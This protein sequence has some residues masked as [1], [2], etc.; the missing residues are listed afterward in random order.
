MSAIWG[1]IDFKGNTISKVHKEILR[2]AYQDCKIDR[3]EEYA[4]RHIYMGCGIQ[5]FTKE[6]E[7]EILP[8]KQ[9]K[10]IITADVMI[11]NRMQLAE[12]LNIEITENIADGKLLCDY[13]MKYPKQSLNDMLGAYAFVDYDEEKEQATIVC[14]AV[15]NRFVHYMLL[16]R[17][18]YFSSLLQ[19]LEQIMENVH[20]N[21]P[22]NHRWISDYI[23]QDNYNMF[24][25]CEETPIEGILRTAPGQSVKISKTGRIKKEKYWDPFRDQKRIRFANDE[26]YKK[27]FLNLY[28]E[29]VNCL[30]RANGE[31]AIFLSG[32][33]DSTSIAAFAAPALEKRGKQ[34]YAFTSVPFKGYESEFDAK[35]IVDETELVKKT[36]E[37]YPNIICE[38][39]DLPEMNPW[40]D[41]EKYEKMFELPYKSP[42]NLL[43]MYQGMEH[44]REKNARIILK[45]AFG[46]GTVS[47]ENSM[48]YMTW[49]LK[50]GHWITLFKEVQALRYKHHYTRKSVIKTTI[51][52]ALGIGRKRISKE[53]LIRASFARENYLTENHTIERLLKRSKSIGYYKSNYK[54]Y[55]EAVLEDV[56]FRHYGE[57]EQRNSLYTGV[58]SRDPTR[59]KRMVEFTNGIP[60][61]QFT[62]NGIFRRLITEYMEGLVPDHIIKASGQGRQSADL[63][64]RICKNAEQIKEE[65]L[66]IFENDMNNP[67]ID[68]EK[69]KEKLEKTCIQDMTDF[70]IV[71]YIYTAI[72]LEYIKKKK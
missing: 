38:F 22:L 47:F 34:L 6:A 33:Y 21:L 15:G 39:M 14:D 37:Y 18:L 26:E 57:F 70:E 43:W 67:M 46:N 50:R 44:A 29:C 1:A 31:T 35:M 11:D 55:R 71:R 63:K 8:V 66:Q 42:Q 12:K 9:K 60:Y 56:T 30:L 28:K 52:D 36:Q 72:F 13:I 10:H 41:R 3:Y 45:G 27:H 59:D 2:N 4:E 58:I 5:Y 54:K 19:P 69:A 40:Y 48:S 24:T 32:G 65:W 49:L 64:Q 61:D 17:V 62:K 25:E 23:G 7:H 68:C 16:D 53:D 51:R 20:G